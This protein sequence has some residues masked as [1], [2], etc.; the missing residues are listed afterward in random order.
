M[1]C[2]AAGALEGSLARC[3]SRAARSAVTPSSGQEVLVSLSLSVQ[4]LQAGH[5]VQLTDRRIRIYEY[6]GIKH[7]VRRFWLIMR[8]ALLRYYGVAI[9]LSISLRI[10]YLE[11]C[12]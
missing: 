7:L 11:C 5:R 1:Q 3:G 8:L 9:S 2:T 6:L 4:G 10:G 12:R